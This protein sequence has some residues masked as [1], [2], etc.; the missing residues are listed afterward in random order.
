MS[1]S[2][3]FAAYREALRAA[4][5]EPACVPFLGKVSIRCFQNDSEYRLG[6]YL[7]DLTFLDDANA[8]M[9]DTPYGQIIHFA[10]RQKFAD[11]AIEIQ[12]FQQ[13]SYIL[14]PLQVVRDWIKFQ[15]D[16]AARATQDALY[17]LSLEIEP[18][19]VR[20]FN[21]ANTRPA[22]SSTSSMPN[23]MS[24]PSQNNSATFV[25]QTENPNINKNAALPPIVDD[26]QGE[27]TARHLA[28]AGFL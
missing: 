28:E 6:Q 11:I 25:S 22:P 16:E 15:L 7:T 4:M 14:S 1:R 20:Q 23:P 10:K 9:I 19:E 13:K 17:K 18:R 8:D 24:P 5:S 27:R 26:S 2:L 21:H 3:N 12:A